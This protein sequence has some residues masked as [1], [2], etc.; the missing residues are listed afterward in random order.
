MSAV[1]DV[2]IVGAG[3]YGLS[4]AAQL[5]GRGVE[6]RIFG[7]PLQFWRQHM[8]KDMLLKSEPFASCLYDHK[9]QFTLSRYCAE[10]DLP[11]SALGVPVSLKTFCQ[12]GLAFQRRLVPHLEQKSVIAVRPAS[13]GFSLELDDGEALQARRV[14]VAVGIGAFAHL[15]DELGHLPSDLVSHSSAH[16]DLAAFRNKDVTVLG[17]GASAID[18]AALLHEQGAVVRLV[19]RSPR[20]EIHTRMRL[21]RPLT[22]RLREPMTGIGPSWRSWAYVHAPLAFRHLSDAR[23]LRIVSNHLGPAGGW[24]MAERVI[25]RFPLL[26]GHRLLRA[27]CAGSRIQLCLA[28]PDGG[29]TIVNTD[30]IVAA[31]GYRPDARRLGFLDPVLMAR[32]S[33]FERTPLLS[34]QFESTVPGLHFVGPISALN[35]GPV[36]RFAYG[37]KFTARRLA[38]H[39]AY[40]RARTSTT[41]ERRNSVVAQTNF[42]RSTFASV[43]TLSA[44]RVRASEASTPSGGEP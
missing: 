13:A 38:R 19:T 28:T 12:Y 33:L 26:S 30:H 41:T 16:H 32:L 36:A 20:L 27:E 4:I 42:C 3:P 24:Y 29:N 40:A 25:G 14:V 18:I 35:F 43:D 44:H 17:G 9:G 39:L 10:N 34:S 21:P 7:V 1:T 15:P 5:A 37:A 23:R 2:A 22:D 31:T 6:H 8:P 11:Y